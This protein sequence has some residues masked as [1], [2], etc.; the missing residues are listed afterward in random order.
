[1]NEL[2][3]VGSWA[4]N[5]AGASNEWQAILFPQSMSYSVNNEWRTNQTLDLPVC[6]FAFTFYHHH[7][8]YPSIQSSHTSLLVIPWALLYWITDIL[9]YSIYYIHDRA[10]HPLF[11]IFTR[12]STS[13]TPVTLDHFKSINATQSHAIPHSTMQNI[14]NRLFS[15]IVPPFKQR[16]LALIKIIIIIMINCDDQEEIDSL[17]NLPEGDSCVRC[18]DPSRLDHTCLELIDVIINEYCLCYVIKWSHLPGIDWC[19]YQLIL[20]ML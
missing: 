20:F 9:I 3:P 16:Y 13:V 19:Y 1:M 6:L 11:Q 5:A 7:N 10:R 17:R 14:Q 12:S 18:G 2:I 4:K 8:F 15:H